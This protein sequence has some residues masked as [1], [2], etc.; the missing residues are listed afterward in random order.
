MY[1]LPQI[2]CRMYPL[3]QINCRNL[4]S[5]GVC[6]RSA[7]TRA[8]T[9]RDTGSHAINE[10]FS[11]LTSAARWLPLK[12]LNKTYNVHSR[13]TTFAVMNDGS[14][15]QDPNCFPTPVNLF[16]TMK[17]L[18][19]VAKRAS[20]GEQMQ[21]RS[22]KVRILPNDFRVA[23]SIRDRVRQVKRG[24]S[25]LSRRAPQQQRKDFRGTKSLARTSSS[26]EDARR[27]SDDAVQH[28]ARHHTLDS[29]ADT[30][31]P[32]S[33]RSQRTT[34]PGRIIVPHHRKLQS[35]VLPY[36]ES[37]VPDHAAVWQLHTAFYISCLTAIFAPAGVGAADTSPSASKTTT[38]SSSPL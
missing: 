29:S 33:N 1:P 27:T 35:V 31:I 9:P 32:P 24:T 25:P 8:H 17:H 28:N 22:L 10:T 13:P 19:T 12:S 6:D 21:A 34:R 23:R 2:N 4:S 11:I 26:K 14:T 36:T 16:A 15:G 38:S 3:P 18:S 37:I 20:A 7:N 30:Y 5:S